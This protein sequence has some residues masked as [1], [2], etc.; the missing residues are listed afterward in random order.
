LDKEKDKEMC[1]ETTEVKDYMRNERWNHKNAAAYDRHKWVSNRDGWRKL[2]GSVLHDV[3]QNSRILD[4]GTGTGFIASI[5]AEMGYNVVGVDLSKAMLD[6]ARENIERHG[7]SERAYLML[8]DGENL[9]IEDNSM[10]SVVSRWVLWT[11]P[12]PG[13]GIEEMIRV[14]KPGGRI[15]VIDG[16]EKHKNAVQRFKT[17]IVDFILTQRSPWW[18]EKF[19][20]EID[21]HL[22]RYSLE[23]INEVFNESGLKNIE[24][25]DEIEEMT[26]N[27]MHRVIFGSGWSSF[28]IKGTKPEC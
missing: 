5:L 9:D 28:L 23:K 13:K 20:R 16:R 2:L 1:P 19:V 11:L 22:P 12:D 18:R 4:F 7:L 10:D 27:R 15:I 25:M 8:S 26:E 24:T 3:G 21:R 14:T 6:R 17:A